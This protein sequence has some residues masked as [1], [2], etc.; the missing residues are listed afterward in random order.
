MDFIGNNIKYL[1]KQKN[2]TQE[3]LAIALNTKRSLIGSY[4]ENRAKPSYE[5]LVELGKF[6]KIS[7]DALI[8]KEL[9]SPKNAAL[10]TNEELDAAG[11]N[12]RVLAISVDEKDNEN[13]EMIPVKAAAGY[14]NGYADPSYLQELNRFRLPF[15]PNGTYRA[16][17]IK[18]DSM[19]PVLP[20]SVV[21]GEYVADWNDIKDGQTYIVLSQHDGIVYKRVFNQIAENQTLI[22]RSDNTSY[23]PYPIHIR[24]VLEVWK[25]VLHIS[26]VNKGNDISFQHILSMMQELKNEVSSIKEG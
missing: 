3:Q 12:L 10:F 2:L 21:V 26:Y 11:K 9:T 8:T 7:I 5:T 23:P 17:E 13:I 15:L 16:F 6:F 24:E 19:L 25:A 1:R 4:E 14:L 20:G 18:G 22:L